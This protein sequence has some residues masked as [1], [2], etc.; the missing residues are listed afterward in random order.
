MPK[1]TLLALL[2]SCCLTPCRA[3][4]SEPKGNALPA[5]LA[6]RIEVMFRMHANLPPAATVQ[7]SPRTPSEFVGYD[8]IEV[9]YS[10]QEITSQPITFLLSKDNK[11]I[12]QLREFALSDDPRTLV[13]DGDRPGRGG[14]KTA[15]VLIVGFDDLECPFC[16][17]LHATIFPAI[18]DR[19]KDQVRVV[20]RD[21]PIDQHPWAMRAAIDTACLAKQSASG[22]WNAVDTIH[23]QAGDLGGA[24]RSL[25]VANKSLDRIVSTIGQQ[26]GVDMNALNLCVDKQD[27]TAAKTS[28]H[29]GEALGVEATPT[30]FI[31][32]AKIAGDTPLAFIFQMIDNALVAQGQTPPPI[33]GAAPPSR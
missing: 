19:Y 31:N 7:I 18:L 16:A 10:S 15:P 17:R 14:P 4:T 25:A 29:D 23:Q 33:V 24:Q 3:Q 8:Q 26:N 27:S 9:T 6:W 21:F 28:Q 22:Y 30:I 5:A 12:M 2:L 20:Y 13:S 32:G 11:K 1:W